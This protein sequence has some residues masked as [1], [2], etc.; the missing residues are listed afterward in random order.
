MK[1]IK[2]LV[3]AVTIT[4]LALGSGYAVS[5]KGGSKGGGGDGGSTC[6]AE[7][8]VFVHGYSGS[9][10]N[11]NTMEGRLLNDGEPSCAMYKFSYNS[12]GESNKTS[13]IRLSSYVNNALNATGQA[14]A[15][16]IAHSN[17][18]LVSRWYRA[19]E[20]G[21]KKTSR[22]I[23][24]G[25]PHEGTNWAYG[26]VSPAC[27]EMRPGSSFLNDLGGRGCDVSI[28]SDADEIIVPT[29]SAAA[30]GRAV[31]TKS[32]GH[33]QLLTD[34]DVYVDVKNNL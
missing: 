33:N 6:A 7:P 31:K 8:I 18:G 30:C 34:A 21:G 22:L 25:T 12:L 4:T 27:F 28:W 23:T 17:G 24:L 13:A 2:H 32:V 5:G 1:R 16:L 19:F 29:S 10:S 15:R 11:W 9:G 26:C 3:Y 20:G 14:K